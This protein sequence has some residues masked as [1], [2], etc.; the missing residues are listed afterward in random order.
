MK[1]SA[2]VG[3]AGTG[4]S[5]AMYERIREILQQDA[6]ASILLIV[7]D[8]ATYQVERELASF[9]KERGFTSVRVVGFG[10]LSHQVLQQLG[11]P[12]EEGIT[13]IG[14]NLLLRSILKKEEKELTLFR[15]AA[16]K[17]NF[18]NLL[19]QFLVECH[20]FGVTPDDLL[21]ASNKID[22]IVLR[23]KMHDLGV[24]T[25]SYEEAMVSRYKTSEDKMERL[26]RLLPTAPLAKG[27]YVFVDGFHWF[28]PIQEKLMETLIEG[29]K[30]TVISITLPTKGADMYKRAGSLF[31]RSYETKAWLQKKFPNVEIVDFEEPKRFSLKL[32]TL[33]SDFFTTPSKLRSA[34]AGVPNLE[35]PLWQGYNRE[36]EV[37]AIARQIL[38]YVEEEGKRFKDMAVILRDAE[39]YGD[40]LEKIFE[41]YEIPYFSDR[42]NPMASH[43]LGEMLEGLF[44]LILSRLRLDVLFRLLKTDLFPLQRHEVDELENYCLAYGVNEADWFSEEEWNFANE[45]NERITRIARYREVIKNLLL[46]FYIF[47]KKGQTGAAWATRIFGLLEEWNVASV[48]QAWQE[49]AEEAGLVSEAASHGQMYKQVISLLEEIESL[50]REEVLTAEEVGIILREG[51]EEMTYSL[52]PPSLDHVTIT[53]ID[54]GYTSSFGIVFVPGLNEGIFPQRMG[55][56]GILRDNERDLLRGTGISLAAGALGQAFNENFLF[57]LAVT[58]AKE[59]LHLSY[60]LNDESGSPLEPSLPVRRLEQAGYVGKAVHI[61]LSIE[62]GREDD[63]LWRKKQSMHLFSS[64]ISPLKEGEDLESMWW[65]FYDWALMNDKEGVRLAT[66]GISDKNEQSPISKELIQELMVKNNTML[67]SVTRLERYQACP[68]KFYAEHVLKAKPRKIRTFG[69]PE[70]GTYLHSCLYE[71]GKELLDSNKQW[72]DLSDADKETLCKEVIDRVAASDTSRTFV[73]NAYYQDIQRRLASTLD[74]TV[75]RLR[76]WSEHS[77]FDTV[78]LEQSFGDVEGGWKPLYFSCGDNVSVR[79][80]GQIDRLDMYEDGN[81]QKYAMVVDYK[82]GQ[83]DIAASDIYYGLKLQLMTYLMAVEK[84][85]HHRIKPAGLV[86]THVRTPYYTNRHA[87][88]EEEAERMLEDSGAIQNTGY[89]TEDREVLKAIDERTEQ[90]ESNFAPIRYTTKGEVTSTSARKLKTEADFDTLTKYVERVVEEAGKEIL[91]GNFAISPYRTGSKKTPCQYCD[92]RPLCR[93]DARHGGNRYRLLQ[94]LKEEDA[95]EVIR[96][97]NVYSVGRGKKDGN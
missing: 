52:V 14:K 9:Q 27:A 76:N 10:R 77:V 90:G 58:R 45:E 88:S 83:M 24:L 61:P 81:R 43:P 4:K 30:E 12:E 84:Q 22:S 73:S 39:T 55:S 18:S 97:G 32:A 65:A 49:E 44:A 66:L 8:P 70:V 89:F 33:E 95:M 29:A 28:T 6:G 63:Y 41:R 11:V 59:V 91:A 57:Y 20:A 26:I 48:L 3:R 92:Y 71:M 5:Y 69:A 31:F 17:P 47:G 51:T 37:D 87:L 38:R 34:D 36:R 82:S 35:I 53:T 50:A 19:K 75:D 86:Y 46:P 60:A 25:K 62:D 79:G 23:E 67:G 42:R 64:V 94:T 7:P 68:F 13:E 93:F 56:E 15:A 72:R 40:L 1:L 78:G 16:K 21:D 80:I 2:Y 85:Y 74:F 96:S 54:R